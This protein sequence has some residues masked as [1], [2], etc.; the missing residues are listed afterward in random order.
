M[1]NPLY[2]ILLVGAGQLGSRY[3]QGLSKTSKKFQIF[4]VDPNPDALSLARRLFDQMPV[5]PNVQSVICHQDITELE[6]E[7]D[8]AIMATNADVRRQVTEELLE[9][10]Q[11][12]YL[13]L[14]KVVFQSVKD[15]EEIIQLLKGKKIMAWVNCTR[16]MYPLFR[17]LKTELESESRIQLNVEGGNLG[18]ASNA[19]HMLDLFA[20]L[21]GETQLAIDASGLDEKVYKSKR[22]GFIEFGGVLKAK[23][24]R[25]DKLTLIDEKDST[26]KVVQNVISENYRYKIHQSDGKVFSAHRKDG[27]EEK[28][29]LFHMPLQSEIT[30]KL[31]EQIL[32]FGN[33]DLTT[34]DESYLLHRPMLNAFNAHLSSILKE[35]ITVCPIT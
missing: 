24:I 15:F 22:N 3:L 18:L 25:G 17:S 34:L 12:R 1:T 33:S 26:V 16:R 27:W 29:E 23:N 21:T 28:E 5:N 20:F 6:D 8:L 4:V 32:D 30:A 31:A 35:L 14:E 13:I 7:F 2:R 19:I 11:V 9:K 10:I